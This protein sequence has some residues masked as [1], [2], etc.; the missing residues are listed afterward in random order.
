LALAMRLCS[1][2]LLGLIAASRHTSRAR[3]NTCRVSSL[4]QQVPSHMNHWPHF[5]TCLSVLACCSAN[6][7][8]SASSE[9]GGAASCSLSNDD[10]ARWIGDLPLA[11]CGQVS[12]CVLPW[13]WIV[14]HRGKPRLLAILS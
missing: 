2:A 10:R 1:F 9:K 5:A 8:A 11:W 14:W 13:S 6:V 3:V 12:Q 4:R 7:S